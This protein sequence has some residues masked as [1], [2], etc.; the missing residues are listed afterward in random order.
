MLEKKEIVKKEC[1]L[2]GKEHNLEIRERIATTIIK[3]EE[4]EYNEIYYFCENENTEFVTGKMLDANL[5][6]AK[7][8]YKR[9]K[10]LPPSNEI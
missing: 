6:N 4:V 2:C 10:G 1:P 5:L 9:M 3:E 7:N 8:A